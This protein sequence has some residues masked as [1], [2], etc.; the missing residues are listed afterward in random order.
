M[1]RCVRLI[2]FFFS[3]L[4]N[5]CMTQLLHYIWSAM[6][7]VHARW[8]WSMKPRYETMEIHVYLFKIKRSKREKV[9]SKK[10][11]QNALAA[12]LC[13]AV[14]S[15][16]RT[17]DQHLA[18]ALLGP[19]I[20]RNRPPSEPRPSDLRNPSE[21]HL[22]PAFDPRPSTSTLD[23]GPSTAT[24]CSVSCSSPGVTWGCC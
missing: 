10:K 16:H 24:T 7:L 22:D 17:I 2:L 6:N 18:P 3:N 23:L 13:P 21:C 14:S 12:S 5:D 8:I 9:R 15:T 11:K 19:S 20:C 4:I 1:L